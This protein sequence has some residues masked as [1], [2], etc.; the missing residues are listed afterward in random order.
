MTDQELKVKLSKDAS[1]MVQKLGE[2]SD[3]IVNIAQDA[4]NTLLG[5][6]NAGK[7]L[8]CQLKF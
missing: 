4:S 7:I 5:I 3:R 2:V 8:S 6:S 1:S